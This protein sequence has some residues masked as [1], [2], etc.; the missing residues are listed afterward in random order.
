MKP[1][2]KK[3]LLIL[4]IILLIISFSFCNDNSVGPG[5]INPDIIK[6]KDCKLSGYNYKFFGEIKLNAFR[7]I[8]FYNSTNIFNNN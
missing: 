4:S 1:Y 7:F 3:L 2:R 8:N 5:N 6:I